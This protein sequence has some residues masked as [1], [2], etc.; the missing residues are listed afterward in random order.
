MNNLGKHALTESEAAPT[1]CVD[2][3]TITFNSGA[4]A[5]LTNDASSRRPKKAKEGADENVAEKVTEEEIPAAQE[6]SPEQKADI[7]AAGEET[8]SAGRESA[9]DPKKGAAMEV[10]DDEVSSIDAHNSRSTSSHRTPSH[11]ALLGG[12]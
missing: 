7:T 4:V 10:D 8:L 5:V 9:D 12:G 6:R 3:L 2:L 11:S 1:E